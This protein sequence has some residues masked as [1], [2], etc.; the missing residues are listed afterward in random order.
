[1][2]LF[3]LEEKSMKYFLDGI[4]PNISRIPDE[5]VNPKEELQR[6]LPE[7][8]QIEGARRIAPHIDIANNS[9]TGFQILLVE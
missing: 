6:Y 3:L 5:I 4:L 7:H 8:Q 2:K 1:M 9:S